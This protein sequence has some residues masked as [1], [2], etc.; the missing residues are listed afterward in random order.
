[1]ASGHGRRRW[2]VNSSS[3]ETPLPTF[4]HPKDPATCP[5]PTFNSS[6]SLGIAHTERRMAEKSKEG[7]EMKGG[8]RRGVHLNIKKLHAAILMC[9]QQGK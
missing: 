5:V 9:A 8:R 6:F 3:P 7:E 1:M 4:S 2:A